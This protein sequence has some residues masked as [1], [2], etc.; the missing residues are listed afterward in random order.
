M[1]DVFLLKR[2]RNHVLKKLKVRRV[3]QFPAHLLGFPLR[4]PMA[5]KSFCQP[6]QWMVAAFAS[7][8]V[9][10]DPP[11]RGL[12]TVLCVGVLFHC[13]SCWREARV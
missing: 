4:N 12:N 7:N 10:L 2:G 3:T 6:A 13:G 1:D 8:P 5:Q 9:C 11:A